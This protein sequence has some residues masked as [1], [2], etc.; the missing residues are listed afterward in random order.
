MSHNLYIFIDDKEINVYQ[1]PTNIT[2]IFFMQHDGE[3]KQR[4]KG[5]EAKRIVHMYLKWRM[6]RLNDDSALF[7]WTREEF[8]DHLKYVKSHIENIELEVSVAKKVEAYW[9]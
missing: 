3:C 2:H 9:L 1:T 6:Q 4:V 7:K 8:Y 5:K